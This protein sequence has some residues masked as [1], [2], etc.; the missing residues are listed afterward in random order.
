MYQRLTLT[1]DSPLRTFLLDEQDTPQYEI[2]TPQF[3]LSAT[4]TIVRYTNGYEEEFAKIEW[5]SI[6]T[7]RLVYQGQIVN[8]NDFFRPSGFLGR[9]QKFKAPDGREYKWSTN[10]RGMD[11]IQRDQP[12]NVLASFKEQSINIFSPSR[13]ARLDIYPAGQYMTDLIVTTFVYVEQKRREGHRRSS[14]MAMMNTMNQIN[15][16]ATVAASAR[17]GAG[18]F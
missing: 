9:D 12:T 6:R 13:N 3:A 4:T 2:S 10:R 15:T 14:N 1:S 16:N 11:L 17:I 7:T 5:H 18:G 8:T